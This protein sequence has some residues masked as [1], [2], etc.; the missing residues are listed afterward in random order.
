[1]SLAFLA[2][3]RFTHDTFPTEDNQYQLSVRRAPRK[4]R[5]PRLAR[6]TRRTRRMS[7]A[8]LAPW[9]FTH[10]AF[11]TEDKQY[12]LSVRR[13]PR[14]SRRPRLPRR[15][16][17][18][19]RMSLAFLAPWRFTHDASPTEDKQYQLSGT[20]RCFTFPLRPCGSSFVFLASWRLGGPLLSSGWRLGGSKPFT[21]AAEWWCAST[22][23]MPTRPP[24]RPGAQSGPRRPG[25][26]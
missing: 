19:R 5:K 22:R 2:P 10:D 7:L 9:R 14:K 3:W 13:A 6:R 24:S 16:R 25:F 18:T 4:S 20:K 11:P 1:M 17:R 23:S 12:H 21:S 15:T 26:W 8:F